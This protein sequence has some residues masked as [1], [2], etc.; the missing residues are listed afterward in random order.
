MERT[1]FE[2]L[3]DL[4]G[5]RI[6]GDIRLAQRSNISA[7]WEA[8]DIL[9][10]NTDGV[11]ARLTVQ[12][13]S[14]TGAKTLNVKVT[15]IGPICRLEVD[16]RPH[17]PA[18]RSHKHALRAST[19]PRENLKRD[20]IDRSDLNGRSLQEVFDV[21]CRMAHIGH[22]GALIVPPDLNGV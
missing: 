15:G 5:K 14:E 12:V 20:V 8:K 2:R 4:P 19:C 22:E 9:I 11:D 1:E 6:I 13:V 10:A 18:G 17:K 7:A 16:S 21:F 3:R